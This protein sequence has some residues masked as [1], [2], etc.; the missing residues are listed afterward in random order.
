MMFEE[1]VEKIIGLDIGGTKTAVV[2]GDFRGRILS[3]KQFPT[4]PG[5]G[6]EPVFREI[7]DSVRSAIDSSGGQIAA[8]SISIGGPLDVLNGI[9]KSPP[10]L[11]T[12]D[13]IHLKKLLAERFHLP[14]FVEHD[15]NA[16]ALAE[17]YF[18]A[19]RGLRNIVFITMGT[20]FGAGLILD[21]KLYRGTND[22]AGEIGHIRIAE[23]GPACYGKAGSLEGYA[24]GSGISKLAAQMFPDVWPSPVDVSKLSEAYRAGSN[25]AREV[26]SRAAMYF[27]RGLAIVVDFLNPQRVILGGLGMRLQE[28]LV[29]P[30][31]RV[32]SQE[33]LS[34]AGAVCEIVPAGLGESIGDFAALCAAYDQGGLLDRTTQ[35]SEGIR[36]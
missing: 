6:F 7:C 14:V 19:G 25:Q 21:G 3:R 28:E 20:G 4:N 18:G 12:W 34:E 36:I 1:N 15:G 16:G 13:D 29:E 17:F 5:R 32:Y 27:G 9:I 26:F 35:L 11:P 30:A 23:S 31:L 33:V 24:S 8:I 2:L 22:V 10:N